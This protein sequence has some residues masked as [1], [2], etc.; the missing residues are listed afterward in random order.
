MR[1]PVARSPFLSSRVVAG[2]RLRM[3][4]LYRMWDAHVVP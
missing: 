1:V 2:R 3:R 4:Y